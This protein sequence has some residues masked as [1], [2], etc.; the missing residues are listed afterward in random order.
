MCERG[1]ISLVQI[2]PDVPFDNQHAEA[3]HAPSGVTKSLESE[4]ESHPLRGRHGCVE[5]SCTRQHSRDQDLNRIGRFLA[6]LIGLCNSEAL[7]TSFGFAA[8]RTVALC[9]FN[10]P[11]R[12]DSFR[13]TVLQFR[14]STIR[15]STKDFKSTFWWSRPS[16][17]L[18]PNPWIIACQPH[19]ATTSSPS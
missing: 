16:F 14:N 5:T 7:L 6:D 8:I 13:R 4:V 15:C 12:V 3:Q 17:T 2:S 10:S 19:V 1:D 18:Y 9:F 11:S